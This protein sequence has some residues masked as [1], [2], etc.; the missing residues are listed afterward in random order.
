MSERNPS[1]KP[2]ARCQRGQRAYGGRVS[3]C[4]R[5]LEVLRREAKSRERKASGRRLRTLANFYRPAERSRAD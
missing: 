3:Y 2:C 1:T 4:Q 5:C